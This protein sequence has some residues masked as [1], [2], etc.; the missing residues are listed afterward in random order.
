MFYIFNGPISKAKLS[1]LLI[2]N[3]FYVFLTIFFCLI[4]TRKDDEAKIILHSEILRK[5][6]SLT[7]A[8]IEWLQLDPNGNHF[9]KKDDGVDQISNR[10]SAH[11]LS[12]HDL[13]KRMRE[14]IA[15]TNP[16]TLELFDD[17]WGI[18][19]SKSE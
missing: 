10:L 5:K 16:E 11:I 14:S 18:E 12:S 2:E 13:M 3:C 19:R 17:L 9:S 4:Q 15:I 6:V 8:M 7:K 1:Y